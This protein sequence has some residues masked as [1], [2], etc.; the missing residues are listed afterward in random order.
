MRFDVLTLFPGIFDG[1]LQQ[2]LLKLAIERGLVGI[3]P[4]RIAR[5]CRNGAYAA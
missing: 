3:K 5:G 2:S 1:Y 4:G